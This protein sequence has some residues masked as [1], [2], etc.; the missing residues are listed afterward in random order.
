VNR[1]RPH[2]EHTHRILSEIEKGSASSQRTLAGSV[3]IALGLT[4]LLLKRLVR[5][6]FVR[7]SLIKPNRVAYFLTPTGIAEKARMSRDAF[8]NSVQ[9]YAEARN[10]IRLSFVTLSAEWPVSS[11]PKRIVFFGTG[12]VAEIGYICLQETDFELIGVIDDQGRRRFFDVPVHSA[13]AL[14]D[15]GL[16]GTAFDRL[17]VMSFRE[18]ERIRG[19]L[20]DAG[21]PADQVFWI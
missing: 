18:S 11:G 21:V 1:S 10:R 16:N 20:R 17:V 3:G 15:G 9:F 13:D 2:E 6:G 7:M 19:S 5:K 4:N 8:Q 14:R 12:E